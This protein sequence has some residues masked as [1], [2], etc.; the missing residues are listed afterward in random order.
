MS[1]FRVSLLILIAILVL[2]PF[3]I[4]SSATGSQRIVFSSG[5]AIRV[6]DLDGSNQ[7][8]LFATNGSYNSQSAAWSPD[9]AK[10]AFS[11]NIDGDYDIFTMNADGSSLVNITNNSALND[12]SPIWSP[13]GSIISY[14]SKNVDSSGPASLLTV[15]PSGLPIGVVASLEGVENGIVYA[16]WSPDSQRLAYTGIDG[17]SN[18]QV[19]TAN[20]DGSGQSQITNGPRS[21]M[22]PNWSPDGSKIFYVSYGSQPSSGLRF[23][24]ADGS[25]DTLIYSSLNLNL[26]TS[27]WL[28][29]SS[30]MLICA[31][32]QDAQNSR[33]NAFSLVAA[34]SS[35]IFNIT[36]FDSQISG[37]GVE[38]VT[39]TDNSGLLFNKYTDNAQDIFF[40]NVEGTNITNLTNSPSI[41]DT[42]SWQSV[43]STDN[44]GG[45]SGNG[46][47]GSNINISTPKP[48]RT[49]VA[50][51]AGAVISVV[52]LVAAGLSIVQAEKLYNSR[53]EKLQ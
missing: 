36:N 26:V 45:N 20:A 7:L 31:Y 52:I 40:T 23:V 3:D 39:S 15:S 28:P 21:N 38:W 1:R 25:T 8:E 24:S 49:G 35:D 13:D 44:I 11:S 53:K 33:Y 43:I 47:S 9:G 17:S 22:K 12:E 37:N 6:M 29:N 19:F 4:R 2:I 14:R 34:A 16:S 18:F 10:I 42:I 30:G 48:P 46:N 5:G 51:I 41:D 32:D 50:V 27:S